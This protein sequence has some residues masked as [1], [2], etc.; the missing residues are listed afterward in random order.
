MPNKSKR[1]FQMDTD[2][3]PAMKLSR[4]GCLNDEEHKAFIEM[5]ERS[6]FDEHQRKD[7]LDRLIDR[8]KGI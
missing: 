5:M 2:T 3:L 8:L 1:T 4:D 7:M 6:G